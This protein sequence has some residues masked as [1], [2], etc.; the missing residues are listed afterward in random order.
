MSVSD[1]AINKRSIYY[2]TFPFCIGPKLTKY[3]AKY[4]NSGF[5]AAEIS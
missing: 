4:H 5:Y 3:S 1:H 2:G